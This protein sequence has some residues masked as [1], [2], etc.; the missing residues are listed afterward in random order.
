MPYFNPAIE[1][2]RRSDLEAYVDES[3][4]YT[5][6]YAAEHSPFYRKWF[7]SEGLDPH[8]I[9]T[10]ED[11][12][13]LP[14]VSG[15]VIRENQP[16]RTRDFGFMSAAPE[17]IFTIHETSGTSGVPKSFFLTWS[18]W[19][20]YAEKYARAFVA[21]GF[22]PGDRVA[23]CA[24]YGMNIGANTMTLAAR[25]VGFAVIPEGRCTFP[26][27]IITSYHPTAIVG[28]VFKLLRLA[29]RLEAEGIVPAGCGI[30]R[31]IVGG[32]SFAEESRRYLSE[33]WGHDVLN[34][35]GSTE[36]TMCGEC[37]RHQGLHVPE[38][39]VHL[40]IYDPYRNDFVRDG[41]CGRLVLTTLIPPGERSGTVLINYDTEDT[42]VVLSR[43]T[44]ECGRTH[45]RIYPPQREAETVMIGGVPVNRV[46]I[47]A[48]VF[49]RDNMEE[50]TGEYEAFIYGGDDEDET[51]IRIS[52]E[53]DDPDRCDR[54]TVSTK[55]TEALLRAK[56][57]LAESVSEGTLN[58]VFNFTSPDG[59]ELHRIKGRPRRLVDRR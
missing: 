33:R 30:E 11:L 57:G 35:Y 41:D 51:V 58:L 16:P 26:V 20:R 14:L 56:P 3:V 43:D 32:E 17:E 59:L 2:M 39:L 47:E 48:A 1:T 15:S 12:L 21:Q 23:I 37:T 50:I 44:C 13:M 38:D 10:H 4:R 54:D 34:T 31:L 52:L 8:E 6:R 36:G 22:G 27:R 49:E 24:S 7:A 45:M 5:V 19:E 9:Q 40:D 28:S 18:D 53:C 25:S 29:R 55:I 46:D 42:S